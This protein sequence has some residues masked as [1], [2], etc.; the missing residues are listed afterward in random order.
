[1][2]LVVRW[3]EDG[4]GRLLGYAY[5]TICT[6]GSFSSS[7]PLFLH[8]YSVSCLA[9]AFSVP[10]SLPSLTLCLAAPLSLLVLIVC[11]LLSFLFP[12][13]LLFPL[14]V[15]GLEKKYTNSSRRS[16]QLAPADVSVEVVERLEREVF[17]EFKNKL[18]ANSRRGEKS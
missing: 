11:L 16:I 5:R 4:D 12:L 1:M 17:G 7:C 14:S 13:L 6:T 8:L 3:D 9:L 10:S 18:S 2:N 15:S